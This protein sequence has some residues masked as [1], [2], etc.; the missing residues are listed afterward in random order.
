MTAWLIKL[1]NQTLMPKMK[2][3]RTMI[4]SSKIMMMILVTRV[5]HDHSIITTVNF[6][7]TGVRKCHYVRRLVCRTLGI[8]NS[9]YQMLHY[10]FLLVC[11]N[12]SVRCWRT[13]RVCRTYTRKRWWKRRRYTRCYNHRYY[14]WCSKRRCSYIG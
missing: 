10:N 9:K 1:M 4:W 2:K 13:K 3:M 7:Y 14:S 12:K 8:Y 5:R 11:R 6:C